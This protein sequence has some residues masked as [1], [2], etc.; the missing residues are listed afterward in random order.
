MKLS[1]VFLLLCSAWSV[2]AQNTA[3]LVS[4]G[5]SAPTAPIPVAPGQVVTLFFRGVGPLA[6]GSLRSGEAKTVPLPTALGGFSAHISQLGTNIPIFSVRQENECQGVQADLVC[7]LTS[8]RVEMPFEFSPVMD[9]VLDVDGKPGR[10]FRL[11]Q[12]G[13]NAHVLTSCDLSWDTNW[14]SSCARLAFHAD[15]SAVSSKSPARA[16]ETLIIYLWGLGQTS[17]RVQTGQPS[18]RGAVIP[19]FPGVT[20]L[21]VRFLDQPLVFLTARPAFYSQDDANDPGVAVGFAG[22]TPEQIGLYQINVAV[23][24]SLHPTTQCGAKV[25]SG[26]TVPGGDAIVANTV[27]HVTTPYVG[28]QGARDLRESLTA[29]MA[30]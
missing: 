7:L 1:N 3:T 24:Q 20:A 8:L 14:T 2:S 4:A 15:G 26:G 11:E 19:Q 27:V 5:Y 18:P 22:L 25:V 21:R 16:G 30:A 28:T 9:L 6:D 23:P 12:I 13:E 29:E 17:P 10:S